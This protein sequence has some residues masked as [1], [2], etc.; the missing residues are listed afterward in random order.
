MLL[1]CLPCVTTPVHQSTFISVRNARTHHLLYLIAHNVCIHVTR[2]HSTPF[3]IFR[4]LPFPYTQCSYIPF[5][6]SVGLAQPHPNA[7]LK[8]HST[9]VDTWTKA[10]YDHVVFNNVNT[11]QCC[12]T[13][14]LLLE[15]MN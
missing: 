14:P 1:H 8:L 5:S 9:I 4:H 7:T 11:E 13:Y 3:I 10:S 6:I 12:Q 15:F 2:T